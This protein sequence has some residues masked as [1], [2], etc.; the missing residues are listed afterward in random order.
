MIKNCPVIRADFSAANNIVGPNVASMKG[1]TVRFTQETV[2]TECVEV[3]KEILD[4]NKDFTITVGVVFVDGLGFMITSSQKIKFTTTEYVA[5][6]SKVNLINSFK[7]IYAIYN[8]HGFNITTSLMD[9]EFEC[10]RDDIQGMILK[11]TTTS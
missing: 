2:L 8:Q 5:E 1:K 6:R 11:N 4:L 7:N 9:R 3:P 10:L